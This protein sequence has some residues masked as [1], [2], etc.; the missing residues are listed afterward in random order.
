MTSSANKAFSYLDR[1]RRNWVN[2]GEGGRAAGDS[3][4]AGGC[5][6]NKH[7]GEDGF[8]REGLSLSYFCYPGLLN[9]MDMLL[10]PQCAK[11]N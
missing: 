6:M 7:V 5:I 8:Y 11:K 4:E 9:A 3:D 2:R 1:G 10:L